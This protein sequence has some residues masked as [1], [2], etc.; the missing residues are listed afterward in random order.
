MFRISKIYLPGSQLLPSQLFLLVMIIQF[1]GTLKAQSAFNQS[2]LLLPMFR[3]PKIY[4][5]GSQLLPFLTFLASTD[6]LPL[7]SHNL[8][9][10]SPSH[11]KLVLLIPGQIY[12]AVLLEQLVIISLGKLDLPA[13]LS[14]RFSPKKS[15][16]V[17]DH[18]NVSLVIP[19]VPLN[20]SS[21]SREVQLK[22]CWLVS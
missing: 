10:N 19:V 7:A 20:P 21:R 13:L 4:L 5:P 15:V 9:L 12:D 18:I 16:V 2:I 11:P 6:K 3:I 1:I 14:F 8:S 17:S 22:N